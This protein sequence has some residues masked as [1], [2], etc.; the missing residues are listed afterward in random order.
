MA[1]PFFHNR[2][3]LVCFQSLGEKN[4]KQKFV[5]RNPGDTMGV[6]GHGSFFCLWAVRACSDRASVLTEPWATPPT[7]GA[8]KIKRGGVCLH[9]SSQLCLASRPS[10]SVTPQPLPLV[11]SPPGASASAI[12]YASTFRHAPLVWLVVALP[13]RFNPHLVATPPGASASTSC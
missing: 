8:I 4:Q 7:A 12:Y 10:C 2:T 5:T 6:S 9:L 3:D 1:G 13:Q 11:A